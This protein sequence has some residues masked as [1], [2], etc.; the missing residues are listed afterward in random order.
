MKSFQ[1]ST[2]SSIDYF[3]DE[4]LTNFSVNRFFYIGS[5]NADAGISVN[6]YFNHFFYLI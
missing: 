5:D 3:K 4:I 6:I 2:N 1:K